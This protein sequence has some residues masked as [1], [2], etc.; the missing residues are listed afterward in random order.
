MLVDFF[1]KPLQGTKYSQFQVMAMNL[2]YHGAAAVRKECVGN[3]ASA[4]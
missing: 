4:Q 3:D 1:M 2:P